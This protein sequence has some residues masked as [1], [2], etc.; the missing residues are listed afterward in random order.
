MA[1]L[2]NLEADENAPLAG[3]PSLPN[4]WFDEAG[5]RQSLNALARKNGSH[6]LEYGDPVSATAFA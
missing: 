4:S 1:G 5:I 2:S 3:G 6:L